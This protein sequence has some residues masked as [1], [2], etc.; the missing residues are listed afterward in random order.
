[1]NNKLNIRDYVNIDETF[2]LSGKTF[3][4]HTS[5]DND[6]ASK[7]YVNKKKQLAEKHGMNVIVKHDQPFHYNSDEK[8]TIEMIQ[9][10]TSSWLDIKARSLPEDYDI[11]GLGDKAAIKLYRAKRPHE[12]PKFVPCTAYGVHKLIE[13]HCEAHGLRRRDVRVAI[14]G[15][16]ELVGKPLAVILNCHGYRVETFD[17]RSKFGNEFYSYDYVVVATGKLF[18][19]NETDDIV[20]RTR[21]LIIDVGIHRVDGK[22]RGDL[23]PNTL[24]DGIIEYTPVPGGVGLLTTWAIFKQLHNS[25]Q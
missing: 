8:V 4:I 7:V 20:H 6:E 17:S 1:M 18:S 19:V 12:L 3:I 21:R 10:P 13:S 15:R 9:K 24:A 11:D 2:D 5:D 16:S 14:L 22:L 25:L 23:E